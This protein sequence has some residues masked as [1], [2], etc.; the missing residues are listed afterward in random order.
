MIT[1]T[2]SEVQNVN[3]IREGQEVEVQDLTAAKRKASSMQFFHGTVM[4]IELH[5]ETVA[6]KEG[7]AWVNV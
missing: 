2:I 3:S 4:K 7:R 6:Y 5:G 1:Y